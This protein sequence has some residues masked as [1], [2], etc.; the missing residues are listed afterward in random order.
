[1]LELNIRT[2][3]EKSLEEYFR[4]EEDEEE[5]LWKKDLEEKKLPK[6]R[7]SKIRINPDKII[8]IVESYSL[9]EA[10]KDPDNPK[11]DSLHIKLEGDTNFTVT[12][13]LVSFDK[14]LREY[15]ERK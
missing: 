7:L 4:K 14:K 15:K 8:S 12:E 6:H 2:Y 5:E 11:Y 10:D 13:T 9:E 3:T 1:M